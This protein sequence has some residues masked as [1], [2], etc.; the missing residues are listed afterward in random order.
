MY[1]WQVRPPTGYG[2]PMKK[3]ARPNDLAWHALVADTAAFHADGH[4]PIAAYSDF[5]PAPFVGLKPYGWVDP[6]TMPEGGGDGWRVS[7]YQQGH[8][9]RPG[10]AVIGRHLL[11]RVRKLGEGG[12]AFEHSLLADNP[13]WP[14]RLAERAGRLP[15]ERYAMLL[16]L[17]LS[18][19]QDDKGRVRWTL[20]GSSHEGPARAFWQ[21]FW[22]G[23][24]TPLPARTGLKLLSEL[25][26]RTGALD[27]VRGG[28]LKRAGLRIL[29][30]GPDP[31]F[32]AWGQEPIPEWAN[33]LV[34]RDSA[35]PNGISVV[36]TFRP[37]ERLPKTFQAAYL[38]G[39]LRLAP[40]P[41]SLVFFGHAGY[42]KLARE[43]PGAMQL[44]LLHEFHAG[45]AAP[46]GMRIPQ[47]GWLDEPRRHDGG[48]AQRRQGRIVQ[49]AKRTHR[50]TRTHRDEDEFTFIQD[51]DPVAQVLFSTKPGDLGLYGKPMARNAQLWTEDYR[52]LLNG[53]V[54]SRARIDDAA[55]AL[56]AGGHFGY[57][58]Y[59]PPM[60]TGWHEVYWHLPLAGGYDGGAPVVCTDRLGGWLV[61]EPALRREGRMHGRVELWPRLDEREIHRAAV[62]LFPVDPG[63]RSHTT[64]YNV[65]KLADASEAL[66]GP[67]RASF[68]RALLT[69][70]R[71]VTLDGWLAT[72]P[73][74]AT[75]P[76]GAKALARR[77]KQLVQPRAPA[78]G[79]PHTFS[80]TANRDFEEKYWKTIA[81]LAEGKFRNK[82]NADV[83]GVAAP[84]GAGRDLPHL[85]DYLH[86]YYR[87]LIAQHRMKGRAMVGD[88]WLRWIT[89]H[90][91]PWMEGWSLNQTGRARERNVVM[92]IPGTDRTQAVV[93]GDHYDTAYMED[94]YAKGHGEHAPRASA[95]GADDNHS[96]TAALMLAAEVLL[97]LS[98]AGRLRH[99][100]WL[101]HL[102]GEEFPSDCLGARHLAERLVEHNFALDA[103]DHGW[104]DLSRTRVRGAYVLDMVAHNNDHHRYVFQIAP[105]EGAGST[106]LAHRAHLANAKWNAAVPEWNRAPERQRAGAA[107]RVETAHPPP[108][109][110]FAELHGE[111]RPGWHYASSLYNT[112]AQIFSDAGIPVVLFMEN[113]DINRK[114]YHDTNDT[115]KNI[116]LDYGAALVAIAIESVADAAIVEHL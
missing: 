103:E 28:D 54:A 65:R 44:P 85:S 94:V 63:H 35:S 77:V 20:F 73:D 57:R 32:P 5:M 110:P 25:L 38:A 84:E 113:Y 53:P 39:K 17:A 12:H 30:A 6:H 87:D 68:A 91:Y 96:A 78:L 27:E 82:N 4:F 64:S 31:D 56:I 51:E 8:E 48:T 3:R 70:S 95:S 7:E 58:F 11:E 41:G 26:L 37:F 109:A 52:L 88:H 15:N 80:A 34:I 72:L 16:S 97:P 50:W 21:S 2:R 40:F 116:D 36:L 29:P 45:H 114:G 100:V 47:S 83:A 33:P 104:L 107:R 42:R 76:D 46:S 62:E 13:Y 67:L 89:E 14:A 112:D 111:V 115:M 71:E 90:D 99:D 66:G 92:V 9:L 79:K 18:R 55:R 106:R 93:M 23:P 98:A 69:V 105:G 86:A 74:H 75:Q 102:T 60:R 1:Q 81:Y 22:S 61:A 10:L 43:L 49:H 108:L 101:V 24:G 59:F 19:T